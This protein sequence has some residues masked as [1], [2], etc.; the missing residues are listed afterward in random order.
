MTSRKERFSEQKA[1]EDYS[2]IWKNEKD[3]KFWKRAA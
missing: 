1:M 3:T 2:N